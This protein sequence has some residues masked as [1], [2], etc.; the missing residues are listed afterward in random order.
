MCSHYITYHGYIFEQQTCYIYYFYYRSKGV[1]KNSV[2]QYAVQQ[3]SSWS[4]ML[5]S[6]S[7]GALSGRVFL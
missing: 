5:Q 2:W 7:E 3:M 6:M 4:Y 1:S